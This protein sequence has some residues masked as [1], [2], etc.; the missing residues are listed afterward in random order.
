MCALVCVCV[1]E[2]LRAPYVILYLSRLT[3]THWLWEFA[4][5]AVEDGTRAREL[6]IEDRQREK[7]RATVRH[8]R[9]GRQTKSLGG[10]K[11]GLDCPSSSTEHAHSPRGQQGSGGDWWA[12]EHVPVKSAV[13]ALSL[14]YM[15][16]FLIISAHYFSI[17][18]DME[19]AVRGLRCMRLVVVV[20]VVRAFST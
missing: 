3:H 2:S 15:G 6:W 5:R 16:N 20:N 19:G 14:C 18:A 11:K 8:R 17:H 10:E 7:E 12:A 4:W 9:G 13:S 1:R